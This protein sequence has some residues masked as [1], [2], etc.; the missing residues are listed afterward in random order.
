LQACFSTG[1][2]AARGAMNWKNEN[3]ALLGDAQE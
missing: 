3:K 2:A 1:V